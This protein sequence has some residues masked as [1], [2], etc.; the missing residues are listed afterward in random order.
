M[1]KKCLVITLLNILCL[2]VVIWNIP[3]REQVKA[4]GQNQFLGPIYYNSV[5]INSVFDHDLPINNPFATPDPDGNTYVMHYNGTIYPAPV[6]NDYRYDGHEGIDYGLTYKEVIAATDGDVIWAGW[7]NPSDHTDAYGLL[8]VIEH[9]NGYRTYYGHLSVVLVRDGDTVIVDR[10]NWQGI[11]A[12]SSSTGNSS[13]PHLHFSVR[14]T[15][16]IIVNPYGWIGL[17]GGDPWANHNNGNAT[18]MDLWVAYPSITNNP[19]QFTNGEPVNR[20]VVNSVS[21]FVIDDSS[22]DFY[23]SGSCWIAETAGDPE[24]SFNGTYYWAIANDDPNCEVEWRIKPDAFS[25]PG[26]YDVFVYIPKDASAA[27][28]SLYTINYNG[29]TAMAEVVQFHYHDN[30]PFPPPPHVDTSNPWAYIG[31][32]EFAMDGTE[33][34]QLNDDVP[35]TPPYQNNHVLVDAIKLVAVEDVQPSAST[36]YYSWMYDGIIGD[37]A[38]DQANIIPM[39]MKTSSLMTP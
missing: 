32:Y 36:V 17:Q 5:S 19:P 30:Q 9:G 13:G 16:N 26:L 7:D 20:P 4:Q 29:V 37:V 15:A 38:E 14:N 27:L 28:D 21:N 6:P 22:A 24:D 8:I 33:T 18:S 35:A 10:E 11:I 34:I 25:P 23:I 31:R 3:H 1:S 2:F 12:I 39:P